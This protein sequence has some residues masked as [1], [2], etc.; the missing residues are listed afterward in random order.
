[1]S[2][3]REKRLKQPTLPDGTPVDVP[4]AFKVHDV[5]TG[6]WRL[7]RPECDA[8]RCSRC[9]ICERFCP[10]QIISVAALGPEIDLRFCKGCGIC[11]HECP[12]G[13]IVMVSEKSAS[14]GGSI[15]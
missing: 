8:K 6:S 4:G 15:G 7:K 9:R 10:L 13:A 3:L 1:M 5:D 11:A 2:S 12:K 14:E